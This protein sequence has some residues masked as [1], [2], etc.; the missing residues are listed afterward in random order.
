MPEILGNKKDCYRSGKRDFLRRSTVSA[1]E[2]WF[3]IGKKR[4]KK[5]SLP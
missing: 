4:K 5:R 3:N 2:L 1:A